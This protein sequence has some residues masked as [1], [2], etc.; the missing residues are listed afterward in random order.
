MA[1]CNALIVLNKAIKKLEVAAKQA[2]TMA[3]Q[4]ILAA[5]GAAAS[6]CNWALQTQLISHCKAV[7]EQLSTLI[8]SV[9]SSMA[10]LYN[11]STQLGLINSSQALITV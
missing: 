2:A 1:S 3:T 6:N 9:Y 7:E 4:C 8:Q 10:N 5:Q 11:P